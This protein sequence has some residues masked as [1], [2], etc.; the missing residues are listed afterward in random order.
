M[1]V[2]LLWILAAKEETSIKHGKCQMLKYRNFGIQKKRLTKL[3]IVGYR[4]KPIQGIL[5]I[6]A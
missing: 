2:T 3:E 1:Y 4:A 6:L 5:A